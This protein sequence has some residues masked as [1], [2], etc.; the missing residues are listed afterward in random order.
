MMFW[1]MQSIGR[2]KL[3]NIRTEVNKY[4]NNE[5]PTIENNL[6]ALL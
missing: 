3:G 4:I 5:N 2:V 1:K 6:L